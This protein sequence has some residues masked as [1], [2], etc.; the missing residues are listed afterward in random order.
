MNRKFSDYANVQE[1]ELADL[2]KM[3]IVSGY[4]GLAQNI[5]AQIIFSQQAGITS[6]YSPVI[7]DARFAQV[8]ET[9]QAGISA[10]ENLRKKE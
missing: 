3:S 2:G 9:L 4:L 10:V 5:L 1:D 8:I 6:L 7:P